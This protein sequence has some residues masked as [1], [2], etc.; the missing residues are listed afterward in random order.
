MK[1]C[2]NVFETEPDLKI[3]AKEYGTNALLYVKLSPRDRNVSRNF[4]GDRL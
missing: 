1:K 2:K 3:P 4:G